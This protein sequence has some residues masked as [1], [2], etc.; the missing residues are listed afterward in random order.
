MQ[1]QPDFLHLQRADAVARPFS[2]SLQPSW[3]PLVRAVWQSV[4]LIS[5]PGVSVS[6]HVFGLYAPVF[7]LVLRAFENSCYGQ[8]PVEQ[9]S[10]PGLSVRGFVHEFR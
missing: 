4:F 9:L 8:P 3:Q 6:G 7:R 10:R 1:K 5:S 2:A